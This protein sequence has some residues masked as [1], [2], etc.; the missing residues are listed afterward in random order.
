MT[1]NGETRS[2][3]HGLPIALALFVT[4]LTVHWAAT[5]NPFIHFDDD[6]HVTDNPRVLAGITSSSVAWSFSALHASNWYPLTWLSHQIDVELFGLDAGAHHRTSVFL[7]AL[8]VVLLF[9]VL[10]RLTRSSWPSAAV[11]LFFAVHPLQVESVAWVA[12]RKNLLSTC[13]GLLTLLAYARWVQRPGALRY[14]VLLLAFALSLMSKPMLV[15]LPFALLLLDVWPL[16]RSLPWRRLIVEKLP[17]LALTAASSWITIIAQ[18]RGDAIESFQAIAFSSRAANALLA[19]AAYLKNAVWPQGLA[20]F[21][22]HAMGNHS[23]IAVV[24]SVLFLVLLTGLLVLLRRRPW[25]LV[26]WL[27]YLGTL[28]PVIGLIQVGGQARADRYTYVP[29][30]GIWLAAAFGGA[31]LV[32]RLRWRPPYVAAAVLVPALALAWATQHQI[33]HWRS[34]TALFERVLAVTEPNAT[35][36]NHYGRQL[37]A[38][39]RMD[40][41][42]EILE[43]A[44]AQTPTY[45]DAGVNLGGLYVQRGEFGLAEDR[46]RQMLALAPHHV[47]ARYNLAI[48]LH[49]AGALDDAEAQYRRT[50]ELSPEHYQARYSLALVLHTKAHSAAALRELD[51]ALRI[52][53][54]YAPAHQVRGFALLV[55]SRPAEAA[56]AF[57]R[58]L[59]IDPANAKARKGL[60][61]AQRGL[62]DS[63][64]PRH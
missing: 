49:H 63:A 8:N 7:H 2:A 17:L 58:A 24:G 3:E 42:A 35:S 10:T 52:Y 53:P 13:F 55:L 43:L 1:F 48:A 14:G 38:E 19:Y 12:E 45:V 36:L 20:V 59:A 28:V 30:I 26:G 11:A 56:A 44:L 60:R 25:L 47:P 4:T 18:G 16:R 6:L 5:Q 62:L 31:E 22:P 27:W 33:G 61:R 46:L 37:I 64:G 39:D 54:G 9:V 32:K 29:L 21:Y 41:A 57:R 51:E 50:L 23:V 40:E 34:G 15:T